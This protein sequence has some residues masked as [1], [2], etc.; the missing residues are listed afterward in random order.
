MTITAEQD[1]A[2]CDAEWAYYGRAR[3]DN[4]REWA[5]A[6]INGGAPVIYSLSIPHELSDELIEACA[7]A[8]RTC[9][10]EHEAGSV[11][12]GLTIL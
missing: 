8:G 5:L 9:R 1:R 12:G 10:Y 6:K 3:I 4:A 11:W 2:R 7:I